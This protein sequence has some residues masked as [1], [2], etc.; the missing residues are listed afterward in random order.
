MDSS[1]WHKKRNQS[2]P[3]QNEQV[4]SAGAGLGFHEKW[5]NRQIERERVKE[6][7]RESVRDERGLLSTT[8]V[9]VLKQGG[10]QQQLNIYQTSRTKH[11]TN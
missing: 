4:G 7:E 6:R 10:K 11:K 5:E 3:A 8:R 1:K 2:P 9:R